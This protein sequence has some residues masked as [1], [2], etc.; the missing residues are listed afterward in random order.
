MDGIYIQVKELPQSVRNILQ[1]VGYKKADICIVPKEQINPSCSGGDG[2]RYFFGHTKISDSH[3]E[4]HVTYGSWG[5]SNA[6]NP[7]NIV[8]NLNKSFPIP[9]NVC[10]MIGYEGGTQPVHATLYIHPNNAAKMLPEQT[11]LSAEEEKVLVLYR[12]TSAYRAEEIK[13]IKGAETIQQALIQK[14]LLKKVGSGL[15][16]TTEGKTAAHRLPMF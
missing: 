8:D 7:G 10:A 16:L 6:F 12:Y 4:C 1:S 2:Y 5:G 15:G 13:R 9:E 11:N 14:G 3:E